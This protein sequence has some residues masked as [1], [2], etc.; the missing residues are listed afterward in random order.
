MRFKTGYSVKKAI[1]LSFLLL[2][3]VIILAHTVISH[4]HHDA[5]FVTC[6]TAYHE[7]D[8]NLPNHHHDDDQPAGQCDKPY[9]HG[10]FEGC[11]LETIYVN[12]CKCK[13]TFQLHDCRFELLPCVST[14]FSDNSAPILD[15]DIGL[16]FRQNPYLQSY[17]TEYISQSLGLRAPPAC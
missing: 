8:C 16:P 13:Q 12:S 15:D 7:N 11:A 6:T 2:A 3:N 17:N 4:H 9:C 1:A 10:S 5:I 14:L